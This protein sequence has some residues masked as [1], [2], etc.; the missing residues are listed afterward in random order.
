MNWPA[1]WRWPLPRIDRGVVRAAALCLVALAAALHLGLAE[2]WQRR[3]AAAGSLSTVPTVPTA[4]TRPA[5]GAAPDFELALPSAGER[6]ARIARLLQRALESGVEVQT[7]AQRTEGEGGV[8]R[9]RLD[10]G[11]QGGYPELRRFVETAL[12]GDAALALVQAHFGRPGPEAPRLDA[13]LAFELWQ[14]A[15][16]ATVHQ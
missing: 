14:R 9:H 6:D 5:P 1:P 7:V 8:E 3:A 13:R 11:A 12:A 10:L 4:P 15:G 2:R 16:G